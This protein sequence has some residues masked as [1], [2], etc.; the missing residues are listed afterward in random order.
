MTEKVEIAGTK[1]RLDDLND[2][3]GSSVTVLPTI[4]SGRLRSA[5]IASGTA[6]CT[7][8]AWLITKTLPWLQ[9]TGRAVSRTAWRRWQR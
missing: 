6:T 1:N 3:D 4:G 7:A 9:G 5:A 8:T 2:I